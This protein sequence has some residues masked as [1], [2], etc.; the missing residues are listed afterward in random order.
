LKYKSMPFSKRKFVVHKSEFE[1]MNIL[2]LQ[3]LMT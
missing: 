2:D 3:R 1:K